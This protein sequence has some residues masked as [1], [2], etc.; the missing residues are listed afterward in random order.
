MQA[1]RAIGS[2]ASMTAFTAG[3]DAG[4]KSPEPAKE[5]IKFLTGP[6]AASRFKAKG[7]LIQL[8]LFRLR[9]AALAFQ[10]KPCQT[11]AQS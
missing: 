7:L 9:H 11:R 8:W 3:I 1:A 6:E 5:L 10:T 4:S 2:R